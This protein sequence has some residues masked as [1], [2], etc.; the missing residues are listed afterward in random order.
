MIDYK[1]G[2]DVGPLDGWAFENPMSN[3]QIITGNPKASGR[4]DF[5]GR[6]HTTRV[7]IW[8]CTKGIFTCIEQGDELMTVLSGLCRFIDNSSGRETLLKTGD[9][10]FIRDSSDVTWDII[11][12][13]TKVF[14][15]HKLDGF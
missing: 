3:Y 2:D 4:I 7:G 11:E 8:R 6:G 5:G 13:V 15:G 9:S 14:F 1:P 12:E 10:L